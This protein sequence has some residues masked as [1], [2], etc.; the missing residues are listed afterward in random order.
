MNFL[1][2]LL[3]FEFEPPFPILVENILIE[4]LSVIGPK[5][6]IYFINFA[7]EMKNRENGYLRCFSELI[8]NNGYKQIEKRIRNEI[9]PQLKKKE[10]N[11]LEELNTSLY[12]L[13]E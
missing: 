9:L 7:D 1:K 4:L 11:F 13:R 5:K 3:L 12:I 10:A 6:T 8:K 2:D